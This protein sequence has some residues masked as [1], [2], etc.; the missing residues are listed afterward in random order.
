MKFLKQY[1]IYENIE[2][3]DEWIKDWFG[4]LGEEK[5]VNYNKLKELLK[6]DQH[7][8]YPFTKYFLRDKTNFEGGSEPTQSIV[9]LYN[10]YKQNRVK[11]SDFEK[12]PRMSDIQFL[13]DNTDLEERI[14]QDIPKYSKTLDV[15]YDK[16]NIL[17]IR[18]TDFETTKHFGYKQ[19]SITRE[20]T[21][22]N[23]DDFST[24][25]I[26]WD[27]NLEPIED[28]STFIITISK[29]GKFAKTLNKNND[30]IYHIDTFLATINLDKSLFVNIYEKEIL[31]AN[32]FI[33]YI[34][35]TNDYNSIIDQIKSFEHP[36]IK[37]FILN[38]SNTIYKI[39]AENITT[40]ED[41]IEPL[42]NF[43]DYSIER[44]ISDANTQSFIDK[45]A[46]LISQHP[47]YL[48]I[49]IDT[50]ESLYVLYNKYT[51]VFLQKWLDKTGKFNRHIKQYTYSETLFNR[52]FSVALRKEFD[53][54]IK[55]E[56]ININYFL[57]FCNYWY[58][59][60]SDYYSFLIRDIITDKGIDIDIES[61][62]GRDTGIDSYNNR[63]AIN[64]ALINLY[65]KQEG[66][67][68]ESHNDYIKIINKYDDVL[69]FSIPDTPYTFNDIL[70]SYLDFESAIRIQNP[71]YIEDS[72]ICFRVDSL[73]KLNQIEKIIHSNG[74]I[75]NFYK[76]IGY[77]DRENIVKDI[78]KLFQQNTWQQIKDNY[79]YIINN[80][81]S[82]DT[83]KW[84]NDRRKLSLEKTPSISYISAY[85]HTQ[86]GINI[87]F[88]TKI[89]NI[90]NC[91][92]D[93]VDGIIPREDTSLESFY[94]DLNNIFK[95]YQDILSGY[96][97][98]RKILKETGYKEDYVEYCIV[99]FLELDSNIS[100]YQESDIDGWFEVYNMFKTHI[101]D[102]EHGQFVDFLK[103]LYTKLV[104]D[105]NFNYLI[106]KIED[107]NLTIDLDYFVE[108][109]DDLEEKEYVDRLY[110]LYEASDKSIEPDATIIWY[111]LANSDD[112]YKKT[113]I[114]KI[115][116]TEDN[117]KNYPI[118]FGAYSELN[119][120]YD[121]DDVF[122]N[123]DRFMDY[124]H[125]YSDFNWN[126]YFQYLEILALEDIYSIFK[127]ASFDLETT[128][129]QVTNWSSELND[130]S[131]QQKDIK[132]EDFDS[133]NSYHK[134][135]ERVNEL[136]N[137]K[138]K[139][140]MSSETFKIYTSEL[141][142]I[143]NEDTEGDEEPYNIVDLELIRDSISVS[144]AK[145][146]DYGDEREYHNTAETQL[147]DI[148]ETW[149]D[150][151]I[152]KWIDSNLV[153]RIDP[154][155]LMKEF[156]YNWFIDEYDDSFTIQDILNYYVDEEPGKKLGFDTNYIHG[157]IDNSDINN[158]FIDELSNAYIGEIKNIKTFLENKIINFKDFI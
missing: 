96:R 98:V 76:K 34:K 101:E 41:T 130:F 124:G 18:P 118:E 16:N 68:Y 105:K 6:H 110:D 4:N 40:R 113:F 120:L 13:I 27:F 141:Y 53:K 39:I 88:K 108:D 81:L 49:N 22:H 143:L 11:V 153:L 114:E 122:G 10:W 61:D 90:L 9:N 126:E 12:Y 144:A 55:P 70:S 112:Q 65:L 97:Y 117:E 111:T 152:T 142:D 77:T 79:G 135:H 115:G 102:Q 52:I 24:V 158:T 14:R 128:P 8:V 74:K 71:S 134:E 54:F 60:D 150:G 146:Q 75:E 2:E 121:I 31:Q 133:H 38:K 127:E 138:E 5:Q 17:I 26:G 155:K 91:Y 23:L 82:K 84:F 42:I 64:I 67:D 147:G 149:E 1:K 3:A 30:R 132:Q 45:V 57:N 29:N 131:K 35:E 85:T 100:N 69:N 37:K 58:Q 156:S 107:M 157:T 25:Y 19:W 47:N 7:L 116:L 46:Y 32:T 92:K 137:E 78:T 125:D 33:K 63:Y 94:K 104:K 106:E 59:K 136:I 93:Y 15:V 148:F 62:R 73:D 44:S 154:F 95:D 86:H 145:A 129:Q 66:N 43:I 72:N 48:E 21:Y 103:P 80:I 123:D 139:E 56:N 28:L 87:K 20:G 51:R 119:F 89:T 140:I 99:P 50:F 83:I 151:K 109:S 36:K